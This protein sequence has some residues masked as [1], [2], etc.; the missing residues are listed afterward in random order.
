VRLVP[1]LSSEGRSRRLVT[2]AATSTIEPP[3]TE[4][5]DCWRGVMSPDLDP[6]AD[7]RK[8][9]LIVAPQ[10]C[11]NLNCERPPVNSR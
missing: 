8:L 7:N 11:I 9:C 4:N 3:E 6:H 2:R 1:C 10:R 5:D